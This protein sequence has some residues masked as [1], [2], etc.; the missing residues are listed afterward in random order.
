MRNKIN[1]NINY[2]IPLPCR[3]SSSFQSSPRLWSSIVSVDFTFES[4]SFLSSSTSAPTFY[5]LSICS[6]VLITD[7]RAQITSDLTG[8]RLWG[9]TTCHESVSVTVG[10]VI[11]GLSRSIYSLAVT[12]IDLSAHCIS[13]NRLVFPLYRSVPPAQ[14]VVH[15]SRIHS[16]Q[17]LITLIKLLS[18]M[19][20][21]MPIQ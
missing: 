17:N 15:P 1:D 16:R 13:W 8:A 5:V 7:R 20:R 3:L 11:L 18:I 19:I 14:L 2:R 10:R 6:P 12:F 21:W 9:G 4:Q